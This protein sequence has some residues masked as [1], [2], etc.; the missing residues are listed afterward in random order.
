MKIVLHKD[1]QAHCGVRGY[2]SPVEAVEEAMVLLSCLRLAKDRN[3]RRGVE[4]PTTE[5]SVV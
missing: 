2:P 1:S 4:Q 3:K 5:G